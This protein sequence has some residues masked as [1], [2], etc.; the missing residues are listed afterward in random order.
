MRLNERQ[1]FGKRCW[2]KPVLPQSQ[3]DRSV[4]QMHP[5]R[6]AWGGTESENGR[7]SVGHRLILFTRFP[8]SLAILAG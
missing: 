5:M 4:C 7:R 3:Q 8:W 2:A 1:R 6:R